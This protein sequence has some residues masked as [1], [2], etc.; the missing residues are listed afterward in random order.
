MYYIKEEKPSGLVVVNTKDGISKVMK[1]VDIKALIERG[2]KVKGI[3]STSGEIKYTFR[4]CS[5]DEINRFYMTDLAN[6]VYETLKSFHSAKE[7]ELMR[8]LYNTF[9]DS[10]YKM[11]S[12]VKDFTPMKLTE[13][14]SLGINMTFDRGEISFK[15]KEDEDIKTLLKE[16][17]VTELYRNKGVLVVRDN[18]IRHRRLYSTVV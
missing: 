6:K 15:L 5:S 11:V 17:K 4:V 7:E 18:R 10:Y 8:Y 2:N 3:S 16:N 13:F 14:I 12:E 1:R 9:R